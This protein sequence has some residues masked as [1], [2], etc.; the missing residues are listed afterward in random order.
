MAM[1]WITT[2]YQGNK[3]VWYSKDVI[4]K[5]RPALE[6]YANSWVDPKVYPNL[7][8]DNKTAQE[9]LDFLN[10]L[11]GFKSVDD[12]PLKVT[13]NSL[14]QFILEILKEKGLIEEVE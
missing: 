12:I 10:E 5:I 2:D 4:E 8:Y 1:K 13:R 7:H 9:V 11:D 14:R 6:L 3:K